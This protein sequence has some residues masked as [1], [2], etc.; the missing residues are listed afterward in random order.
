MRRAY[1]LG[2]AI[3]VMR[4]IGQVESTKNLSALFQKIVPSPVKKN[5][6]DFR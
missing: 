3:P 6:S 2:F 5:L 4:P 1:L